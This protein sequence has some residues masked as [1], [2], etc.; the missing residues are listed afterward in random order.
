[1]GLNYSMILWQILQILIGYNLVLPLFLYTFYLIYPKSRNKTGSTEINDYAIIVTAYEQ[2]HTLGPVVASILKL[3]YKNFLVYIVA[4]KCDISNLHFD[5]DRVV[6]LRPEETLSSNTRS[7]FY[8]IHRF[9]R[10]HNRI[11]IIDSDNLV[12]PDYLEE[13]NVYFDQ[14]FSAVQGVRR[15]KNMD[16]VY[17][18]LDAA[19]DIY[20]NYYVGKILFE[21]GSSATL[22]GS[23]M[24]FTTSLYRECLEH[25]DIIGA[26]FD[27]ILQKEIVERGFRIAYAENVVVYDEKTSRPDQLV[28]QRARW[29]NTW[30]KYFKFGFLLIGKG[31]TEFNWNQFLFGIVLLRPPLFI[32]LL[33]SGFFMVADIFISPTQSFIWLIGF[34]IFIAG[35][36]FSLVMSN[37][38]KRIYQSLWGIPKFVFFQVMS[39]LKVRKANEISVATQHF[40]EK[41]IDELKK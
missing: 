18:C 8:A 33:L 20:Y 15:A 38:D 39:L 32:F 22:A 16:S 40:S 24:A 23:G 4:D 9:R 26:G 34:L 35:F 13:L 7:H 2:T 5:D 11:T 12:E 30:F 10:P 25:L 21:A 37:T 41:E 29:I 28:N 19:R 36:I 14:G 6:L 1:M 3:R 17:A 31:I 27:K